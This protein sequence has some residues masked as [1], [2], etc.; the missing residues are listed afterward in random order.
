VVELAIRIFFFQRSSPVGSTVS[1][2]AE[3]FISLRTATSKGQ[4]SQHVDAHAVDGK[5]GIDLEFVA[6]KT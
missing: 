5:K 6:L 3:I 1:V 4:R 2:A